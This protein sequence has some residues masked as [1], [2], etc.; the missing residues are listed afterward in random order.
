MTPAVRRAIWFLG[1]GQC[2]YWGML[3]YGF[4]V[5]LEPVVRDLATSRAWVAGAFSLGLLVMALAAPQIGRWVDRD[6]AARVMRVGAWIGVGGLAAASQVTTV[7]ELYAVWAVLGL[8]M[9]T[10]FYEPVF[11]LVI[12]TVSHDGDRLR[13]LASV[14]VLGGLASTIFLP[15]M[16][17]T[18]NHLGWR[19]TEL[20]VAAAFVVTS[21]VL[22]RHVLPVMRPRPP[23]GLAPATTV[24]PARV[25]RPGTFTILAIVFVSSWLGSMSLTTLL[26]PVVI[27]GGHSATTAATV[28]AAL[29][30]MQLPGRIWLLRGGRVGSVRHLL[31]SQLAL[32]ATGMLLVAARGPL[33]VTAAGVACFGAGAGLHTLARPWAIQ[34]IY[35][36]ADAG[37][38]NGVMA[39]YEGFARASG[40]LLVALIYDHA[41]AT[42]V[43]GG[44]GLVM[45]AM[46]P[47]AWIFVLRDRKAAPAG[48]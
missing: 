35:G 10:L 12:R 5:V 2:V 31:T 9:A 20:V 11:G 32:Q 28:L 27:H 1:A 43:F 34:S 17:F 14:T 38:V 33:A 45:I 24:P 39:R 29:G 48:G 41:G 30:V 36:V 13:A 19:T 25:R 3:Y 16:A 47:V 26:I 37:R 22:Q 46:A 4:S 44:L 6:R 7:Y 40:P 18:L 21:V 42:S 8:A 23:S 15:V